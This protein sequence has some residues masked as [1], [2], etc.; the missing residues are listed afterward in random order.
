VPVNDKRVLEATKIVEPGQ[1]EVL[2]MTA[3]SAPGDYEFV[4]TYPGH[5]QIMWGKLMVV[6]DLDAPAAVKPADS[7]KASNPQ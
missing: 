5:W 4:C 6:K 1:K 7:A 2:K 3:P